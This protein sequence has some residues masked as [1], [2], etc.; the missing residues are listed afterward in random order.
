MSALK[1][2]LADWMR[3]M[4][5]RLDYEG[6]PKLTEWSFTF[7]RGRG[8]VFREDGKGC[9]L[10]YL[11]DAEYKR[12]HAEADDPAP[13]VPWRSLAKGGQQ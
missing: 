4:A 6:A 3:K 5:D 8:Q 9:R 13:R 11:D 2:W 10:A 7:E 1:R 12:A